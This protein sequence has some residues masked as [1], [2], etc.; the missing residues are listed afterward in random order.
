MEW[1]IARQEEVRWDFWDRDVKGKR[2]G[3]AAS[4]TQRK[5]WAAQKTGNQAM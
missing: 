4:Q 3:R 1:P 2:K 5:R